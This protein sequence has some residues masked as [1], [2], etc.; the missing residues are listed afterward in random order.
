M[1]LKKSLL[2]NTS[3]KTLD[4]IYNHYKFNPVGHKLDKKKLHILFQ[5]RKN[6]LQDYLKIPFELF[7]NKEL[8]EIGAASG[9]KTLIYGL[10]GSKVTA[11]EPNKN[12]VLQLKKNFLKKKIKVNA[13]NK[14]ISNFKSNKKYDFIVMENFLTSIQGR[15]KSLKIL[16]KKLKNNGFL[17]F[18]YHNKSGFFFEYLKYFILQLF[19]EKNKIIDVN[20]AI[21][22]AQK[23]FLNKFNQ[24]D[25]TRSFNQYALDSL[26][27]NNFLHETFWDFKEILAIGSN[28]RLRFYSSWPNY[29]FGHSQWH[30]TN[31]SNKKFNENIYS[32]YLL[33]EK[34][35]FPKNINLNDYDFSIINKIFESMIRNNKNKKKAQ[36]NIL[37]IIASNK[38]VKKN[39][40]FKKIYS[41]FKYPTPRNYKNNFNFSDWGYPNHYLVFQKNV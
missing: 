26:I 16:S 31:L 21:I 6:L 36:D 2:L 10:L 40:L 29:Y 27:L 33:N 35:F 20:K 11:V 22:I 37:K 41:I 7:K 34:N 25:T 39:I 15:I 18:S 3:L 32:N 28:E 17:I 1:S 5:Q 4:E 12:F 19:L 24:T 14:Y 13:I 9:E 8:L 23:F 38:K 30:K